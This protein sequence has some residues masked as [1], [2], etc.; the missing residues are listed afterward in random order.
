MDRV[1]PDNVAIGFGVL[2]AG[3]GAPTF[4]VRV[5]VAPTAS[6]TRPVNLLMGGANFNFASCHLFL[7][8]ENFADLRD[9]HG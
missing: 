4:G 5:A 2:Q 3:N 6:D 7:R 9:W 1:S 8:I